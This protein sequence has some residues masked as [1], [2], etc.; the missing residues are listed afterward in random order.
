[1]YYFLP[2]D[3]KEHNLFANFGRNYERTVTIFSGGKLFN[4]TG[5]RLGWIIGP[6]HLVKHVA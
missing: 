2:Y 1:M 5:W 3:G 6:S 4:A